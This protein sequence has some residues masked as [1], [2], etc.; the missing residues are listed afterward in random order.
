MKRVVVERLAD[1]GDAIGP[2]TESHLAAD[3]VRASAAGALH[4]ERS[5]VTVDEVDRLNTVWPLGSVTRSGIGGS[6]W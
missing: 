3:R 2:R 5:L 1:H 6:D 4:L